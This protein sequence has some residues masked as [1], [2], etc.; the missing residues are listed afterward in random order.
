MVPVDL[1]DLVDME[2]VA[3]VVKVEDADTVDLEVLVELEEE[4]VMVK[5]TE[6]IYII[7]F[8]IYLI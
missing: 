4:K 6:V 7:N 1:E 8:H 5:V 2:V 3:D